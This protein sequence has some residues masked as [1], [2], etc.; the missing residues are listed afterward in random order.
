LSSENPTENVSGE[1]EA[2]TP[3]AACSSPSECRSCKGG[4]LSGTLGVFIFAV[5]FATAAYLTWRT[6][7]TAPPPEI[8]APEVVYMC[9]EANKT[10][11]HMPVTGEQEP[12]VSPYSK[13][14][15]GYRPEACYWTKDNEQRTKPT[16]VI[17]NERLGIKGATSCPDCGHLVQ[18]HNPLPPID[19]PLASEPSKTAT[20]QPAAE[21]PSNDEAPA[22]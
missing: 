21:T 20:T 14:K 7:N 18:P 13:R 12:I 16:Y 22:P 19:T 5:L 2:D 6:Y 4:P 15:T 3:T 8:N 17:L 9:S 10:F 1:R 11:M